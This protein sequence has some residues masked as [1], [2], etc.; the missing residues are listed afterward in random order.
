MVEDRLQLLQG[1]MDAHGIH[2][3]LLSSPYP[4]IA[5]FDAGIRS[6]LYKDYDFSILA[7][8]W[9]TEF[10]DRKLYLIKD[11]FDVNYVMFKNTNLQDGTVQYM[12][13][14]PYIKDEIPT[15]MRVVNKL[16]L[17]LY[18]VKMLTDYY[19]GIPVSGNIERVI[20]ALM[21]NLYPDNQHTVEQVSLD[22]KEIASDQ[23]FRAREENKLSSEIIAARYSY[24]AEMLDAISKGDVSRAIIALGKV[25]NYRMEARTTDSLREAKNNTVIM[26][27]LC[28]KAVQEARVHP[29]HIDEV[30]ASFARRIEACGTLTE[31]SRVSSDIIRKYCALV[32][33]YSL[34]GYT[35][36]VERAVNYIHFNYAGQLNLKVLAAEGNTNASYLSA[37]FKKEVGHTITDY[38]HMTRIKH[39]LIL[40]TT[41][42]L[43]IQKVAEKCGYLD[44]NYFSKIFRKYKQMTPSEYRAGL[45]DAL[46]GSG[47]GEWSPRYISR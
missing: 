32:K 25:S 10:E 15:A 42:K 22:L 45:S 21:Q 12:S 23:E 3:F 27:V 38:I 7:T 5:N 9:E 1:V 19:N 4:D 41:T 46:N 33:N 34:M 29:A 26:N 30:S 20:C 47:N 8:R 36:A 11:V 31:I 6:Q 14:G 28:R 24:E 43:P 40:L 16:G 18:H 2:F 37:Q 39:A 13:I 35:V 44:E 17:E